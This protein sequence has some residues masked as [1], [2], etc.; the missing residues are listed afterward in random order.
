MNSLLRNSII[1]F[2]ALLL[3]LVQILLFDRLTLFDISRP[4]PYV[5]IILLL[6]IRL[7][8]WQGLLA[9][10]A[11]GYVIDIFNYTYG[12]H[13]AAC[14]FMFFIRD[15]YLHTILGVTEESAGQEPHLYSIGP[16]TYLLYLTGLVFVHHLFIVVLD[17]LAWNQILMIS[18]ATIV[19]TLFTM[20]LLVIIEVIFFYKRGKNR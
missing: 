9:A 1:W 17:E 14:V 15:F 2:R 13:A 18:V 4:F 6:P 3:L 11:V 10:F 16:S 5:F 12:I 7:P 20:L 19:N 8:K